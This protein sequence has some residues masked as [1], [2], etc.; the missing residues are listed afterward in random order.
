MA[1]LP[2]AK[3]MDWD[4]LLAVR[5]ACAREGNVVVWTNGCFDLLHPGHTRS[6]QAARQLGDILVVGLNSDDS[7]RQLK[8][9]SRPILSAAE[10]AEVLAALACVDYVLVFPELR[11]DAALA[12]LKPDIH[13]KGA[14]YAPPHGKPIPEAEV[15]RSYGGQIKFLPY[16]GGISTSEIIRRIRDAEA[17]HPSSIHEG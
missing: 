10:R 3:L 9:P 1:V 17:T 4:Q 2:S 16:F 14:E 11:P 5:E 7:V 13:C 8:G 6:L 12:R 15:V